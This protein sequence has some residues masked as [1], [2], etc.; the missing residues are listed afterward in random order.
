MKPRFTSCS[1]ARRVS[2]GSGIRY[3]GSGWI[4]SLS[5]LVS[6]ASRASSA[7]STASWA[8]RVPEGVGRS[9]APAER[10]RDQLGPRGLEPAAH[11][12]ARAELA[13]PEE[14][15]VG[16]GHAGDDEGRVG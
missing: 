4:S 1:A 10:A 9:G 6:S 14:Q 15:A 16:E 12:L 7:A 11:D 3:F 5:Q 8:V 13:G 2:T